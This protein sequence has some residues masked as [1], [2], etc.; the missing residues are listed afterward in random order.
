MKGKELEKLRTQLAEPDKW[1][2]NGEHH[3]IRS[4]KFPDFKSALAFVNRVGAIADRRIDRHAALEARC[5]R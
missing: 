2:M 3:I 5:A 1:K 4:F